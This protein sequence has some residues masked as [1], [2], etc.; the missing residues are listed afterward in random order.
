VALGRTVTE[1]IHVPR[2]LDD[3][4]YLLEL[5]VADFALDAAPSR[6]RLYPV[7]PDPL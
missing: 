7:E 3:G 6:P 4:R 5:G 2:E 1:M